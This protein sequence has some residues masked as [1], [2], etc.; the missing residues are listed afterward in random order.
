MTRL[1]PATLAFLLSAVAAYAQDEPEPVRVEAKPEHISLF[2]NGYGLVSSRVTLQDS[3]AYVVTPLPEA[4]MGTFW[5]RWPGG[6]KL[7]NIVSAYENNTERVVATNLQQM[8]EANIGSRVELVVGWGEGPTRLRGV[9]RDIPLLPESETNQRGSLLLLQ[10]D[11]G[12]LASV[13][14]SFIQGALIEGDSPVFE[15]EVTKREPALRFDAV[16]AADTV[17][18]VSVDTLAQGIAWAPSYAVDITGDA[19]QTEEATFSAK[20]IIVNDLIDLD[21]VSAELIA[22][23]PHLQFAP[24]PSAMNPMP[25][26]QF[27]QQLRQSGQADW[28]GVMGNEMAVVM[29]NRASFDYPSSS[30]PSMPSTSVMGEQ[31]EDL[32]FYRVKDVTLAKGERGYYPLFQAKI[33]FEHL[34]TW[35]IPSYIDI[36]DNYRQPDPQQQQEIVW[37]V[38]KLTNTTDRP[39]TTAPASTTK[40]GRLLGQDTLHYTPPGQSTDLRITQALNVRAEQNEYE[41]NRERE[42]ARYYGRRYDL[43]T[44]QG[45]LAVVNLTGRPITLK[46][47]KTI[48]GELQKADGEPEAN[49]LGAALRAVNPQT[50]LTWTV[51][52]EPGEDNGLTLGYTF[53]AY[54]PN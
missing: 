37:H 11:D 17:A 47:T 7:D 38:L 15:A 52:A 18:S 20:A 32:Y 14:I 36:Y 1:L 41:I 4:T 54:V 31:S 48:T 42:A 50:R 43:V 10:I 5:L 30:I 22:G 24:V 44:F 6:V 49:K 26:Q 13:P 45:E 21:G 33:P 25:L 35:D 51:D 3:G 28:R 34:Y 23:F 46:I 40:D 29:Q 12:E 19:E 39:W 2:K 53:Q 8:L 9:I 27:L 16:V